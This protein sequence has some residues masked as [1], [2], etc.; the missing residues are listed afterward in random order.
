MAA[1]GDAPGVMFSRAQTATVNEGYL[2]A[3]LVAVLA[4]P[5]KHRRRRRVETLPD[6]RRAAICHL[7]ARG[8]ASPAV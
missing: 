8:D 5:S 3:S 1:I 7:E 2:D 4:H 6:T